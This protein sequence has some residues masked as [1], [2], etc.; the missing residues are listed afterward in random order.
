MYRLIREKETRLCSKRYQMRD[1]GELDSGRMPNSY[2]RYVFPD[3]AEDIKSHRWFKN[4][5]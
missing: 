2:G 4:V 1:R 5:A 3:D